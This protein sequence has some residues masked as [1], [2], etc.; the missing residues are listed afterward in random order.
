[1][2]CG[3][4][5]I[6]SYSAPP[7]LQWRLRCKNF[8]GRLARLNACCEYSTKTLPASVLM[9]RF[10]QI[11]VL[12][13][14]HA[15]AWLSNAMAITVS[16]VAV[17]D[18]GN[19]NDPTTGGIYGEV[20]YAYRIGATEVT[21][22]QYASFLNAVA[23]SDTY[24]LYNPSM[25]TDV[26]VAGIARTGS[27]GN[28]AYS[29]LGSENHPVTYVSW[30]DAARF[31]NW[32]TNGQPT[33]LQDVSTTEDG[34]YLLNGETSQTALSRISRNANATW[35]IPSEKEWYKAAY[36]QPASSGGDL[37]GYWAYPTRSNSEPKSDQ[38]PGEPSISTNVANFSQDDSL[39]N[40]FNDGY[41]VTGS[42]TF[43]A[44][45]NYLTNAGA[46]AFAKSHYG[47]YDQG[48]NVDEWTEATAFGYRFLRGGS[49]VSDSL[50]TT[51]SFRF[52]SGAGQGPGIGF[53]VALVP[54]PSTSILCLA[55]CGAMSGIRKRF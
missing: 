23:I 18:A 46:Y 45:Q 27:P 52:I 5:R 41:A 17:G 36:H 39:A 35:V 54:E 24:G 29:V 12:F 10:L 16:T 14:V 11:S 49:W 38:P 26:S 28:Y 15:V 47:T 37:D 43:D 48:G 51:S 3:K 21:V 9:R 40:G 50:F 8:G 7:Q 42:T 55:L 44:N 6:N 32:M 30:G 53:R 1:M 25:A 31:A 19:A 2:R 20:S 4:W 33:G 13:L 34:A 22:G